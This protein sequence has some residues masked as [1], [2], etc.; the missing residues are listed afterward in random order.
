MKTKLF[1]ATG[2]A[3]LFAVQAFAYTPPPKPP[4]YLSCPVNT[5]EDIGPEGTALTTTH[6]EVDVACKNKLNQ[7]YQAAFRAN[8]MANNL[9]TDANDN[10]IKPP[11]PVLKECEVD[12]DSSPNYNCLSENMQK[13]RAYNDKLSVYNLVVQQQAAAQA[14]LQAN[15]EA[16]ASNSTTDLLAGAEAQA[17]KEKANQSGL[18]SAFNITSIAF[19]VAFAASCAAAGNCNYYFAAAS[20]AAAVMSAL[21]AKQAAMDANTANEACLSYNK[22]SSTPKECGASAATPPTFPYAQVDSKTGLCLPTAPASCTTNLKALNDKGVDIRKVVAGGPNGFAGAKA[23]FKINSDGSVTLANGKTYTAENFAN[24]QAM[25]KAGL[26]PSDAKALA[27]E[28][29]GKEGVLAK[30]GLNPKTDLSTLSM[31]GFGS[32]DSGSG[33][34][35]T[36]KIGGGDENDKLGL[37]TKNLN[38]KTARVPAGQEGLVRDFNGDAIGIAGD[39]IFKMVNKRY[40]LKSAQD[41]FIGQ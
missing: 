34:S 29:Y 24:E 22:I 12:A 16:R 14:Q 31:K 20:A 38:G 10:I 32:F 5:I 41:S 18:S 13:T 30:T 3:F 4:D 39:D 11:E 8:A 1:I 9:M 17:N 2:T 36:V 6:R 23:P 35:A 33:G 40:I 28:F 7:E 26:S 37:G 19:G 15:A 27:N 25:L 21:S